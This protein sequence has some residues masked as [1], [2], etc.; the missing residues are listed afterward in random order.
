MLDMVVRVPRG[1]LA[2]YQALV[3]AAGLLPLQRLEHPV[4]VHPGVGH[5]EDPDG[6]GALVRNEEKHLRRFGDGIAEAWLRGTRRLVGRVVGPGEAGVGREH[7]DGFLYAGVR[8][9][10]EPFELAVELTRI[11]HGPRGHDSA[12]RAAISARDSSRV[13]TSPLAKSAIPRLMPSET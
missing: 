3:M 12:P 10:G 6:A 4:R 5:E 7:V 2:R 9:G 11:G 8:S 13:S 1:R